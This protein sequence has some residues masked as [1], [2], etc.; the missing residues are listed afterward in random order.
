MRS[1]R[2][3][4]DRNPAF[5]AIEK[6]R[7]VEL[8]VS[9][10]IVRAGAA[11]KPLDDVDR[12]AEAFAPFD[13]ARPPR[14]DNVLVET[15]SGPEAEREAGSAEEAEGRRALGNDCRMVAHKW[16]GHGSHQADLVGRVGDGAKHR[17]G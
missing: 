4:G 12:L 3:N 10:A 7:I 13:A 8:I 17:P 11:K 16:A 14:S 15:L 1:T 5:R 6:A 9:A 2:S